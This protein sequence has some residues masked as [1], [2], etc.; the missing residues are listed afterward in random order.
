MIALVPCSLVIC[1]EYILVDFMYI[2]MCIWTFLFTL[3]LIYKGENE[4][5]YYIYNK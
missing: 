2:D 4:K 1:C 3:F 5:T